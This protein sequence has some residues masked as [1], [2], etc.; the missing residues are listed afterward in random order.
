MSIHLLQ[1]PWNKYLKDLNLLIE[2]FSNLSSSNFSKNTDIV[3]S[4][5]YDCTPHSNF[6]IKGWPSSSVTW[7]RAG[8]ILDSR[9]VPLLLVSSVN[10]EFSLQLG[11][12][13]PWQEQEHNEAGATRQIQPGPDPGVRGEQQ[14]PHP[15]CRRQ[16]CHQH[17]L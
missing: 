11:R 17:E 8:E 2:F 4:H 7:T 9:Y 10:T 14:Q 16:D 3:G 13:Q 15:A 12:D 6:S 1:T 5:G